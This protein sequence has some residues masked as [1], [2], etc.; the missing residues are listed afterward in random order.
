MWRQGEHVCIVGQTG[1]GK[2]Y[3]EAHLLR[4]RGHVLF[5]RTKSEW[6]GTD[7]EF[8]GFQKIKT[9]DGIGLRS[10]YIL[11][12][13]YS[14]QAK[15]LARALDL[16]WKQGR[17]CVA[18]DELFYTTHQLHIGKMVERLL[19][20]GRS[21]YVSV[22]T[23]MQRPSGVTRYALSQADHVFAFIQEPRDAKIL[24]EATT[25]AIIPMV[26]Q[27]PRHHFVYFNRKRRTLAISE[28]H[29]LREVLA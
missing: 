5:L 6:P 22:V 24:G 20:Q 16:A 23:G 10:H 13:D 18:V 14:K 2:S 7:D 3:L 4:F 15:E 1:T 25:E 27:L 17:W 26:T 12:P 21:K 9:I 29:H 11:E 19:T 8:V 28:A